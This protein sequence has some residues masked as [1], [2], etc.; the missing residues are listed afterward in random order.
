MQPHWTIRLKTLVHVNNKLLCHG[1]NEG[2]AYMD[3]DEEWEYEMRQQLAYFLDHREGQM[4]KVGEFEATWET[5][6]ICFIRKQIKQYPRN[7]AT[8]RT[9]H[10]FLEIQQRFRCLVARME[11]DGTVDIVKD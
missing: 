4:I 5:E 9:L 6:A 1:Q 3:G 7:K 11:E 2:L 10:L 8:K